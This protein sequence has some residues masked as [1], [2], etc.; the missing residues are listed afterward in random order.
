MPRVRS[1]PGAMVLLLLGATGCGEDA[2]PVPASVEAASAKAE[3]EAVP[4]G[5]PLLDRARRGIREGTLPPELEA[6]V[7]ESLDPA[8]ARA[9]RVL[10]A[11][12][13]PAAGAAGGDD[14]GG[15]DGGGDDEGER[16][17]PIVPPADPSRIPEPVDPSPGT[18]DGTKGAKPRATGSRPSG[19]RGNASVGKLGLRSTKEGAVLTIMAGS[20]LVVGVANQPASGLVRLVIESAH[21]GGAVLSA[22]PRTEGAAVTGVRQGQNTVQIT[23][24]LEPGWTLGSVRPFPGGAKVHLRAPP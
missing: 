8:H 17:S 12:A 18:K 24:Q 21:A 1:I 20:S 9:R 19:P 14:G 15:N 2:E 22:R 5:D 11:M 13:E 3:V 7:I 10:L 16:P 6:E 23:V 4:S